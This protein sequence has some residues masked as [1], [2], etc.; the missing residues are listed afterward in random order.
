MIWDEYNTR[1]LD[2]EIFSNLFQIH[3][4]TNIYKLMSKYHFVPVSSYLSQIQ[5]VQ[6]G[7]LIWAVCLFLYF[8]K[9]VSAQHKKNISTELAWEAHENSAGVRSNF[10]EY[11]VFV[12]LE[13]PGHDYKFSVPMCFS[14]V[15]V[16]LQWDYLFTRV[17]RSV[18]FH[19][20]N[21]KKKLRDEKSVSFKSTSVLIFYTVT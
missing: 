13:Q 4:H 2:R 7:L 20:K 21:S 1:K 6:S 5:R 9:Y 8:K 12:L 15:C 3:H 11:S 16:L 14:C 17:R 18:V 19:Q 10:A